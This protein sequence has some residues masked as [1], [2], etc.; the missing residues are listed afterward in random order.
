[1]PIRL[2]KR[3]R[4]RKKEIKELSEHLEKIFSI[5]CFSID[6][7]ID[8]ASMEKYDVIIVNGEILGLVF[9]NQPFLTVKGLLKF[10][11]EKRYVTVDMGA[12]KYVYNGADVMTPGVVNA[13]ELIEKGDIVWVRDERNLQPLAVGEALMS[14]KEMISSNKGKGVR[15]VHHVGDPLWNYEN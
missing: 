9:Q 10:R 15:S 7:T 1:M 2:R 12:V 8:R 13:D 11:P 14:G 5:S 4:L 6:D 3:H